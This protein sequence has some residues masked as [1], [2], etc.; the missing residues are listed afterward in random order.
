[1]AERAQ[2]LIVGGGIIGTSVAWALAAR[3]VTGIEVVDL[4]LAGV[5]ASSEAQCRRCP[6]NL[7]AARQHRRLQGHA[8]LLRAR[9]AEFGFRERGYLWL[10]A[11]PLL[12]ARALE[13]RALQNARGLGVEALAPSEVWIRFPLLDRAREEIVGATFSPRDGLVNP[14]AV[15]AWGTAARPNAL[16]SAFAIVTTLR[17]SLRR[18]A[19]EREGAFGAYRTSTW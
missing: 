12:W 5:Y 2:V 18:A 8:R 9:A 3:G 11:D 19:L 16:A 14:N 7:V 10:Y 15:R 1:M 17:G 4:D 13:K 6:R